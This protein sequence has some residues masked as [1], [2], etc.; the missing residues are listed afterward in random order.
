M[1]LEK[2]S[3]VGGVFFHCFQMRLAEKKKTYPPGRFHEEPM[4]GLLDFI[5]FIEKYSLVIYSND[6]IC[7]ESIRVALLVFER[8][9]YSNFTQS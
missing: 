3:E 8:Y 4:Y 5:L 1:G 9:S 6:L 2:S 7:S